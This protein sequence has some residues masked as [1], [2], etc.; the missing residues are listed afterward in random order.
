MEVESILA[1]FERQAETYSP[2]DC[3]PG[4]NRELLYSQRREELLIIARRPAM[5]AGGRPDMTVRSA[6]Q[7]DSAGRP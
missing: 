2:P 1:S 7:Q 6:M 3:P 5:R 4:R